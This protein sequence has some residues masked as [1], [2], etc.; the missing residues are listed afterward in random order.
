MK[1]NNLTQPTLPKQGEK[2]TWQGGATY[3][4]KHYKSSIIYENPP[5]L[6]DMVNMFIKSTDD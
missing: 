1:L 5:T 2:I 3:K 4:V 6:K